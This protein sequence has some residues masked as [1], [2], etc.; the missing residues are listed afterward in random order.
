[1]HF[2]M[3]NNN[4][5]SLRDETLCFTYIYFCFRE[6]PNL[7][8]QK[9]VEYAIWRKKVKSQIRLKNVTTKCHK[10]SCWANSQPLQLQVLKYKNGFFT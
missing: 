8:L 6:N 5:E 2:E 7:F 4:C 9:Y 3:T 1:M 10:E